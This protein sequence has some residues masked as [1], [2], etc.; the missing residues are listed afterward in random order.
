[1]RL[2]PGFA[3][4]G[5]VAGVLGFVF[6]HLHVGKPVRPDRVKASLNIRSWHWRRKGA[7]PGRSHSRDFRTFGRVRQAP[8]WR[9]GDGSLGSLP[10]RAANVGGSLDS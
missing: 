6:I 8:S 2:T 5:L 7:H 1:M 9:R 3:S 10:T 4:I